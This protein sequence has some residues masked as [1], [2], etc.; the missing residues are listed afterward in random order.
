MSNNANKMPGFAGFAETSA[1]AITISRWVEGFKCEALR[2]C[3]DS[4][5]GHRDL[6]R[7]I[8]DNGTLDDVVWLLTVAKMAMPR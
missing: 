6:A 1:E 3:V 5:A 2:G 4:A 7:H 8:L